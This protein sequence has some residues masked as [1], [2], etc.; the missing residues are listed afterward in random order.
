MEVTIDTHAPEFGYELILIV[1]LV[2]K[3]YLNND[4]ITV[5]TNQGM[6]CFYYFLPEDCVVEKYTS[7]TETTNASYGEIHTQELKNEIF[8]DYKSYFK[9]KKL[10]HFFKKDIII[11]NNK[12]NTEWGKN[13]I[14]F[15]DLETLSKIFKILSPDF[16]LIY[17]RPRADKIP[18]DNSDIHDLGDYNLI[19]KEFPNVIDIN[20]LEEDYSFNELQLILGSK[21]I[22][23]ISVQ[24]GSSILSSFTGGFNYIYAVQG[25]EVEHNTFNLWYNKFSNCK[26][27][28]YSKYNTL[29]HDVEKINEN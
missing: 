28:T 17:N 2:Y 29:L 12:Y 7:R 1:P 6:R 11:V 22:G 14:N 27:K 21:S 26:I 4:K 8:P 18:K 5:I 24:G 23:K 20:E 9:S 10:K 13:P 15:L 3:H 16:S 19:S 25:G